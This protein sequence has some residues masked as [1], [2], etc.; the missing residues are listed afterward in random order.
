MLRGLTSVAEASC[1]Q[2]SP[3]LVRPSSFCRSRS[4]PDFLSKKHDKCVPVMPMTTR[5]LIDPIV[6]IGLIF[7]DIFVARSDVRTGDADDVSVGI[8]MGVTQ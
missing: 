3:Y 6:R 5:S 7:G 8:R 2:A 1:D 4:S